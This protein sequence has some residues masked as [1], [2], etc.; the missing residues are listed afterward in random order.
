MNKSSHFS[1]QIYEQLIVVDLSGNWTEQDDLNYISQLSEKITEVRGSSWGILV[2]M[3]G[4]KVQVATTKSTF[5]I[6]LDRRNQ[7]AEFWI[8]DNIEQGEFL[9]AHFKNSV[10]K[11]LKFLTPSEAKE[12]IENA[13]FD[14]SNS[15]IY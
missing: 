11:P 5:E 4:W 13:G 10:I 12:A 9:L 1:I 6:A 8:V 14:L 7:R 2:D 15:N 3:R